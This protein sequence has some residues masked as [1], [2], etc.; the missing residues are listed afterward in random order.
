MLLKR[1]DKSDEVKLLQEFLNSRG[2]CVGAADGDFGQKTEIALQRW[3]LANGLDADGWFGEKSLEKAKTQG[4]GIPVNTFTPKTE[5]LYLMSAGHSETDPGATGNGYT[6]SKEAVKVRDEVARLL[7]AKGLSVIEDGADGRNEPLTRAIVLARKAD[8]AVEFH[9]NAAASS[10]ASG[11]EV[12]AKTNN[13]ILAQKIAKGIS[14]ALKLPLRGGD[15]GYKSDS[16]GQHHR[17]GFAEVGGLIVEICFIS[18]PADMKS[19]KN[20]FD[21]MC[22]AIADALV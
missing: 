12:L 5:K 2:Y 20:N 10:Q 15:G 18:N 14:A 3:Q 19:Y 13:R 4:W 16:S 11:V 21:A 8:V 1:G 6:E 17:L 7:R 9:F 22:R